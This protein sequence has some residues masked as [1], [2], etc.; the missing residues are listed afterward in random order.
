M[1]KRERQI[2]ELIKSKPSITQNQIAKELKISRASV[3]VHITHIIQKGF[4]LGRQYLIKSDPSI[5]VIGAC[6][7][8]LQGIPNEN[9]KFHDSNIG[10]INVGL[11]GV[12]RNIA[13]NLKKL[14]SNVNF[15]TVLGENFYSNK[16]LDDLNIKR[17]NTSD[18]LR[19]PDD[20]ISMYL[21]IL[22]ENG[23][24]LAGVSDMN[25]LRYLTPE[26]LKTKE[27]LIKNSEIIVIDTNIPRESIEYIANLKHGKQ[28]LIVDTVSI[29]KAAKIS[30]ILDK[31]DV[32]KTNKLEIEA[33]FD[34]TFRNKKEIRQAMR[35]LIA[36]GVKNI[37][38]TLG[39]EGVLAMN[40]KKSLK[41]PLPLIKNVVDVTGA[42]DIFT[43]TLVF[44]TKNELSLSKTAKV[45]QAASTIKIAQHGTVP[46]NFSFDILNEQ[47]KKLYNET[48]FVGDEQ[49]E[50]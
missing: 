16:I 33:L 3:A 8:D 35:E 5:L 14:M 30:N 4:I 26:F 50:F 23:E 36:K 15:I 48:I 7:L 22:D 28:K 18:I 37:Y 9:L 32:L 25:I 13:V 31:I 34:K 46:E 11:G 43:A 20:S 44:C 21:S 17:I 10:K 6:N 29:K 49:D 2:Y 19:V 38:L 27:E 39:H 41:L 1:T 47:V 40:S 42:G 12:G 24:M 45:S